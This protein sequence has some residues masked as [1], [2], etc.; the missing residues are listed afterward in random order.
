MKKAKQNQTLESGLQRYLESARGNGILTGLRE[1]M[2][3]WPVYAAA[4]GAALAMP[5]SAMADIVSMTGLSL[6]A[7]FGRSGVKTFTV[8]S[9]PFRL[10]VFPFGGVAGASALLIAGNGAGVATTGTSRHLASALSQSHGSFGP[11]N[12]FSSGALLRIA[13]SKSHSGNWPATGTR[14]AGIELSNG[15]FGWLEISLHSTKG[16][17]DSATL[18]AW[19]YND[20]GAPIHAGD[21]GVPEPSS[22]ALAL[23]ATGSA[24]VLAWR[25]RRNAAACETANSAQ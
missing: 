4:A 22:L 20:S 14:F 3:N 15:D 6:T 12:K 23:L 9:N 16:I 17:P 13:N 8:G 2:G 1:H 21:T 19:A 10:G 7:T 5:T 24:G 25:R 11:G 18:L